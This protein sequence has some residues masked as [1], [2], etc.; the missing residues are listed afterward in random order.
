MCECALLACA[1]AWCSR[2]QK[3]LRAGVGVEV[4]EKAEQV[5]TEPVQPG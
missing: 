4:P 5:S 3:L 2:G 1:C